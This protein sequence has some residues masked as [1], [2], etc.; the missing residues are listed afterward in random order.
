MLAGHGIRRAGLAILNSV[1]IERYFGIALIAAL[2]LACSV[3]ES[4]LLVARLAEWDTILHRAVTAEFGTI[5]AVEL[6][7]IECTSLRAS[8]RN[9]VFTLGYI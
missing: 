1:I 9:A 8:S 7:V 2:E 4:I 5:F 3:C 6:L